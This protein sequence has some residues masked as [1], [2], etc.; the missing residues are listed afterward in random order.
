MS[1]YLTTGGF[2]WRTGKEIN[3]IVLA[4]YKEDSKKTHESYMISIMA[5]L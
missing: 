2:R 5:I 3:K 4:K 1:Q